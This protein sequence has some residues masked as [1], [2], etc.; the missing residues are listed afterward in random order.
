[1]D[2]VTHAYD[3]PLAMFLIGMRIHRPWRVRLVRQVATA[4]PR[5]LAELESSRAD[6]ARGTA[7]S[8]GFLGARTTIG[9]GPTVIQYWRS[10]E[11]IYAYANA[12][13]LGHRPAWLE[14]YRLARKD[15]SAVT[16]WHETY[17]VARV[18]SLYVGPGP[19]GLAAIAGSVPVGRRGET[20]RERIGRHS[21]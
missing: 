13:R 12:A 15:P 21:A 8:L 7:E 19:F 20:A 11:D 3:G 17:E 5:M 4:M 10:V 6:A 18:E 2:R 9:S 14:F 1:M 16:I